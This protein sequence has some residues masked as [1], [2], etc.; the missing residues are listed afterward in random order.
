M[1]LS[2]DAKEVLTAA[3]DQISGDE[4]NQQSEDSGFG[5]FT[6]EVGPVGSSSDE[7]IV[8]FDADNL[9]SCETEDLGDDDPFYMRGED[10]ART[11]SPGKSVRRTPLGSPRVVEIVQKGEQLKEEVVEKGM[12]LRDDVVEK[13]VKLT[14]GAVGKI[15]QAGDFFTVKSKEFDQAAEAKTQEVEAFV[16]MAKTE[17]KDCLDRS[18]VIIADAITG[19]V[20]ETEK[21]IRRDYEPLAYMV[22]NGT[23]S[24]VQ[25]IESSMQEIP[26]KV[27][28]LARSSSDKFDREVRDTIES[29]PRM[30]QACETLQVGAQTL[31]KKVD[32]AVSALAAS[33]KVK[34]GLAKVVDLAETSRDLASEFAETTRSKASMGYNTAKQKAFTAATRVIRNHGGA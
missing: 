15:E 18:K 9:P 24:L 4:E 19:S 8:A 1:E 12:Q 31:E 34:K 26:D 6:F 32:E 14:D 30:K 13:V 21:A 2:A 33:P 5:S 28:E 27:E 17:A 23:Q 22:K 11:P 10:F 20:E 25:H 3:E 29:S 7:D 16:S